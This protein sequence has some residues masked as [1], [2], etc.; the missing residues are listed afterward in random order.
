[1][2]RLLGLLALSVLMVAPAAAVVIPVTDYDTIAGLVVVP[3][4]GPIT[5][6]IETPA[7]VDVGDMTNT[8]FTDGTLFYYVHTIDLAPAVISNLSEFNSS[9]GAFQAHPALFAGYSFSDALAAGFPVAATA[10]G[11]ERDP[12]D[13]LDFNA[14]TTDFDGGESITFFGATGYSPS[15][16]LVDYNFTNGSV[17]T[18]QS[19]A[20]APEPT[21]LLL[22]GTGLLGLT[23]RKRR[24][25]RAR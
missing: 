7:L 18:A 1:M 6:D 8:V 5:D 22:L 10:F 24:Q 11:I 16:T 17:A 23:W 21:T 20:P 2:K 14:T 3:G 13:S 25:Q 12:D 15:P 4:F 19:Y 9:P